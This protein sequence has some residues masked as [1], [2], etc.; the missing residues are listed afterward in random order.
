MTDL[1]WG[2]AHSVPTLGAFLRGTVTF[3]A[4]LVMMQI[5][6]QREASGL[7]ITCVLLVVLVAEA[8]AAGLHGEV[9]SVADALLPLAT[10]LLCSVAFDALAYRWARLGDSSQPRPLIEDGQVKH[11]LPGRQFRTRDEVF[12]QLRRRQ[13]PGRRRT[14]A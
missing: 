10:I 14:P 5:V 11:H 6:D 7:G 3:I 2:F 13:G 8:A 1:S 12:S 9:I 4:L